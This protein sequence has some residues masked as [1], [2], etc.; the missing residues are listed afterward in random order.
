MNYTNR[1]ELSDFAC[2]ILKEDDYDHP[3]G[4]TMSQ[5]NNPI[6]INLLTKRH[7]E[8]IETD[9]INNSYSVRG[10]ALHALAALAGKKFKAAIIEERFMV[11]VGPYKVFFKPDALIPS[12]SNTYRLWDIKDCKVGTARREHLKPEWIAQVNCYKW[13]AEQYHQ[14]KINQQ[15]VM[16]W[17]KD[18]S[19]TDCH[20][21]NL[22]NYPP[23]DIIEEDVPI[24]TDA[25]C[26]AYI[27]HEIEDLLS[28]D[29][30]KDNDLP[31][32]SSAERWA[33]KDGFA[34]VFDDGKTKGQQVPK[35]GG[36]TTYI[37]A[38][39]FAEEKKKKMTKSTKRELKVIFKP[40]VSIRCE[41]FCLVNKFCNQYH[42]SK[43]QEQPF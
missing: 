4:F 23:I 5:L 3:D 43:Q 21:R 7:N 40:S 42:E 26:K 2:A 33:T 38:K 28:E 20:E 14:I 19:Y 15:T 37:E 9:V 39:T 25:E 8:L 36:Y 13:A 29:D 24:W 11:K 30:T 10:Q 35:G 18:W 12:S 22:P 27:I 1:H 32:C 31:R 6:R 16:M 17:L 34:V 41:R